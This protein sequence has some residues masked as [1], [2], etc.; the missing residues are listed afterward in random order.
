M[1][2]FDLFENN[3]GMEEGTEPVP[4]NYKVGQQAEY[5]G[6]NSM[7]PPFPVV[8]TNVEDEYIEFRSANGRPIP[9]TNGATEWSADPGWKVLIPAQEIDEKSSAKIG[10]KLGSR[11]VNRRQ[12]HAL[13]T[14]FKKPKLN[15]EEENEEQ[16][17]DEILA[18]SQLAKLQ[19]IKAQLPKAGGQKPSIPSDIDRSEADAWLNRLKNKDAV[20]AT[21]R[22]EDPLNFDK[23]GRPRQASYHEIQGKIQRLKSIKDILKS[24]DKTEP[25]AMR[26][27]NKFGGADEISTKAQ[28]MHDVVDNLNLN[29]TNEQELESIERRLSEYLEQLV[30][31]SAA[32]KKPSKPSK[33]GAVTITKPGEG[34]AISEGTDDEIDTDAGE[35]GTPEFRKALERLKQLANAGKPKDSA[36]KEET[37]KKVNETQTLDTDE[38]KRWFTGSKVVDANG[39]PIVLYHGTNQNIAIFKLSKE[40]ALGKGIYM[41]PDPAF[42][43]EYAMT[44]AFDVKHKSGNNVL[45][46]YAKIVNPVKITYVYGRDM[47]GLAL[48]ALG[49]SPEKAS[50]MVEKAYEVKGNLTNEIFSRAVKLGHDGILY[51]D[52]D[53]TIR[54]AVAF[55][56]NQI[57][58]VYNR[59]PSDSNNISTEGVVEARAKKSAVDKALDKQ[60]KAYIAKFYGTMYEIGS[61]DYKNLYDELMN[62]HIQ[63]K[64]ENDN[65]KNKETYYKRYEWLQALEKKYPQASGAL[66][67]DVVDSQNVGGN[68]RDEGYWERMLDSQKSSFGYHA[69]DYGIDPNL[70][71]DAIRNNTISEGA[72]VDRMVSHIKSSEKKAGKS[73]KD[74]ESIAWATANKRGYLDNKNKK[75]HVKEADQSVFEEENRFTLYL[76]GKPQTHHATPEEARRFAETVK[77]KYPD[78]KIEI[79]QEMREEDMDAAAHNP[80]GAK[81]GGYYKGTQKGAPRAGQGFGS[82]EEGIAGN[83]TVRS[84][85]LTKIKQHKTLKLRQADRFKGNPNR[86]N[87]VKAEAAKNATVAKPPMATKNPVAKFAQSV[88][89]GSGKHQDND[90]KS[91]IKGLDRK[92]K[93]KGKDKFGLGESPNFL[94]W[95]MAAGYNVVGNP[96][97][98]EDAKRIYTNLLNEDKSELKPG[99][100][101][102]WTVHFDD[103]SD[104]KVK[105]KDEKFDVAKYYAGKN[106]VVVNIDY[107]WEA[108]N[109]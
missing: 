89:K 75:K 62:D 46:L 86:N 91:Q 105:V 88:A 61:E 95:A 6:L 19:S 24:I 11:L 107:N 82:M 35:M 37:K 9:N 38:F 109:G 22:G 34:G 43:S 52:E 85:P 57:K 44:S 27:A 2:L 65:Q 4:V 18:P 74:A 55:S 54:E 77:L 41:T 87:L 108:H 17:L 47:A 20:V 12:A 72:K 50:D 97:V 30:A 49:V 106:Q 36:E 45:P 90:F 60:I 14:K 8:I 73:A 93:H 21:K 63:T 58:S 79:K 104:K 48:R 101:Y 69:N 26:S 80:S 68:E 81:F 94:T 103:G 76:N 15:F 32:W 28:M 71:Y 25:R 83:M 53:G 84:D 5:V 96:R 67:D 39:K 78:V 42:A 16:N 99:Q 13:T 66:A 51:Y 29:Y 70:L 98:Y 33:H 56:S 102:I 92:T 10:A 7:V 1:N 31:K 40:G 3:Q 59:T 23:P 100:Y 64:I